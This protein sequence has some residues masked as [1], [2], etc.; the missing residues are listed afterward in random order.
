M[1]RRIARRPRDPRGRTLKVAPARTVSRM[2]HSASKQELD[3]RC[4]SLAVRGKEA[5][6]KCSLQAIQGKGK[7]RVRRHHKA[8][9]KQTGVCS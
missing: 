2:D 5:R 8:A 3:S 6:D 7:S 4:I 9:L 1:S